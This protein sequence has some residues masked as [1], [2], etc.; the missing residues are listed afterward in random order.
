MPA[1]QPR[2]PH[3]PPRRGGSACYTRAASF[4]ARVFNL[5]AGGAGGVVGGAGGAGA[6]RHSEAMLFSLEQLHCRQSD[7]WSWLRLRHSQ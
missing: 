2:K 1:G 6:L 4:T 7:M 3:A 5:R